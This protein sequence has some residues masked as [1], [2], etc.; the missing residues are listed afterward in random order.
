MMGTKASV[1][2]S[3]APIDTSLAIEQY[4]PISETFFIYKLPPLKKVY[5]ILP[6]P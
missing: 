4:L 6:I 2:C 1:G 3:T 5:V